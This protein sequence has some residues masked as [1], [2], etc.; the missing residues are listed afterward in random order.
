MQ[1]PTVT[2]TKAHPITAIPRVGSARPR[3]EV[4]LTLVGDRWSAEVPVGDLEDARTA[5]C[6]REVNP[7]PSCWDIFHPQLGEDRELARAVMFGVPH[8]HAPTD[9]SLRVA[10]FTELSEKW[11]PEH[12]HKRV[13]PEIGRYTLTS[14]L[15]GLDAE[16][17]TQR[18]TPGGELK[19]T[20][21][22]FRQVA[23]PAYVN[24]PALFEAVNIGTVDS[25]FELA[26]A[27]QKTMLAKLA[28]PSTFQALAEALRPPPAGTTQSHKPQPEKLQPRPHINIE[29]HGMPDKREESKEPDQSTMRQAG[30][31]KAQL[32]KELAS[33][34][35]KLALRRQENGDLIAR[36]EYFG[37]NDRID[38]SFVISYD[39]IPCVRVDHAHR[40]YLEMRMEGGLGEGVPV[41]AVSR[42]QCPRTAS[43]RARCSKPQATRAVSHGGPTGHGPR[44]RVD[45]APATVAAPTAQGADGDE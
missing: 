24:M 23:D 29:L 36:M 28:A 35:R 10:R 25:D 27:W 30:M 34:K 44:I 9:R 12:W 45:V 11:K 22:A 21:D 41:L 40:G 39:T 3:D 1:M 38:V 31:G 5:T 26:N 17:L 18:V 8:P 32:A 42:G 33:S 14:S 43:F 20:T 7:E 13:Y 6:H 16:A 2:S 19:C 4:L 37:P 15:V